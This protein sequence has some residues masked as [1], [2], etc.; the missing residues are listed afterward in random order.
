MRKIILAS[1]SPTRKELMKRLGVPFTVVTSNYEENLN[2]RISPV[3]LVKILSRG[4]A[5]TIAKRFRNAVIIG[6]D[7]IFLFKGEVLGKPD[8][9]SAA[10][11]M[12]RTI[13]NSHGTA[14][15]GLTIIDTKSGKQVSKVIK[16]E[17]FFRK[18]S[19]EEIGAYVRTGEPLDKAGSFAIL[20]RGVLFIKKIEGDYTNVSG[21]PLPTLVVEIRKFGV[22]V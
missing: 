16:T 8:S 20:E 22:R 2:L 4:K 3:E 21:L 7:S 10:R 6:A 13:S 9:P 14:I 17:V 11:R 15:T 1:A 5:E 12:L 19:S 18:L